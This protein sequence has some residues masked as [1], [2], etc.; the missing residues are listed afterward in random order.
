MPKFNE[1]RLEIDIKAL[2]MNYQALTLG[3]Q[4]STKIMGVVKAFAYGT[5]SIIVGKKLVELGASYLAVAYI[6]EGMR[7]RRRGIQTPILVF[8]PQLEDLTKLIKYNLI[9]SVYNFNFLR[10][11]VE[12][13]KQKKV[14]NFPIHIKMNTGMNRL[15][16]DMDQLPLLKELLTQQEAVKV[17][18]LFSH[19]S[20]AG[21][22]TE[23]EFTLAQIAMFKKA[24]SYFE[25]HIQQGFLT[26]LCNTSGSIN[27]P[28][29][30]FDMVRTG[31]GLYGY[32]NN[33]KENS[34][35]LPIAELKTV[36]TQLREIP[37]GAS[38]G[39]DRKFKATTTTKV[40][41]L[42]L[43]YADGISRIYGNGNACVLINRQ[44]AYTIGNICMDTLMVDVT[45]I[46]DCKEGAEVLVFGKAH[47]ALDFDVHH[48]SIPYELI[49]CI[50]QRVT[51][52]E[53]N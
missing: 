52:E 44:K 34:M 17:E 30:E 38:V 7:F 20:A 4:P 43:G 31:I 28:E 19:L 1:T 45:H 6:E 39:Y 41:T 32:G 11:L 48:Q 18:A 23:K 3:L 36:I 15:G 25:E 37:L 13:L 27:F 22:S 2:S 49:T 12:K 42:P 29:A 21:N 35:V 50:S 26:H 9:P 46:K 47:T 51:R 10:H 14:T 8:Y 40:A 53:A 24:K 16:F 33:A 5:D